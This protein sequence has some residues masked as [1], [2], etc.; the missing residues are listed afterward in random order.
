MKRLGLSAAVSAAL[1]LGLAGAANA[2]DMP[3]PTKAWTP[4]PAVPAACTGLTDFLL[5]NCLLSWYGVTFYGTVDMGGTYQTHGTPFDP[6]FPT[7]ASYLLGAG[8]GSANGRTAGFGLGPNGMSQSNVGVKI[9]EPIAPGGWSFISVNELAFD[10]YSGLLSNA[11]QAMQNGI[12]QTQTQAALPYDSSRWG[13]LAATNVVGLSQPVFGTVTFGRQNDLNNDSLSSFDP[14]GAA[15]AFS[16]IGYSGKM[17]GGGG[18][19][20]A[21]WTTA[22]KYR[23]NVGD[24]HFAVEG[25]PLSNGYAT[26]NPNNGAVAGEVGWDIKNFGPGVLSLNAIGMYVK[27]A[28]NIGPAGWG[29]NALGWG[30]GV[31]A[32]YLKATLSDNTSFVAEAKYSFGSW[33]SS[34]PVVSKA[35]PPAPSGIPLTLYAG[36]E[37]IQLANPSDPQ[38][39]FR[40]DGFLFTDPSGGTL[41]G[42]VASPIGTSINNNAFNALCGSGTVGGCTSEIFQ[43]AWAGAKYGITRNLDLIAADYIEWQNTFALNA[44]AACTNAMAHSFCAGTMNVASVAID[45]RFLPKWDW[46]TGVM[47]SIAAGGI[48]NGDLY[49]NNVAVTSGVR[50]RF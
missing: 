45:W 47:Y 11:P 9:I 3:V 25:Q 32:A 7:G 31:G 13:W 43:Y 10:P 34:A 36:Y 38:S 17:A 27:D 24:F 26:Y 1:G 18:T 2:A 50:F 39:S 30:T 41:H 21:R 6:N 12:G 19:E 46:Y 20:E 22:I 48:A 29:A 14:F 8:G 40:D 5:S 37:W 49:N 16:L 15:Y 33:G 23:V 42:A 44:G 4:P 35:P 28:V